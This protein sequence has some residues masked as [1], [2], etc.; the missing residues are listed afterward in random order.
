[1]TQ[2]TQLL[3]RT[4]RP[5]KFNRIIKCYGA[6]IK[7]IRVVRGGLKLHCGLIVSRGNIIDHYEN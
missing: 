6:Y 4:W 2:K 1:M 7:I 3:L 5:K